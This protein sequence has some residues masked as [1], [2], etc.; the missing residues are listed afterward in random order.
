MGIN[1]RLLIVNELFG[2]DMQAFNNAV[3]KLND[4]DSFSE[5][6]AF[7]INGPASSFAWDK[8]DKTTIARDFVQIVR[9]KYH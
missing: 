9:R 6:S 4:I 5:A 1:Q 3:A 8:A 2:G 7:L